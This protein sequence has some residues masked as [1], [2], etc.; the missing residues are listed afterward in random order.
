MSPA[1]LFRL[2]VAGA[3]VMTAPVAAHAQIGG[4]QPIR[5][6]V[7]LPAGATSDIVARLVADGIR[8]AVGQP[9]IVENRPGASG[10]IA[11]DAFKSAAPDGNTL[12]LAPIAV[13]VIIPLVFRNVNYDATKDFAPV[14]QVA[15]FEYAFAVAANHPARDLAKFVAWSKANPA[16]ASFG[17][18]GAGSLPHFL[19]VGFGRSA[20]IELVHVAYKGAAPVEADLMNGQITAGVSALS[21][22]VPLH[23]AGRLRILATSGAARSPLLPAVPTFREQGYPAGELVGWHGVFAP[24]GTPQPVVERL[25]SA[26]VAALRTSEV[27]EKFLMFGLEPTGTT[28][29]QL[30]AI[31]AADIARWAP[32]IKAT[33]FSAE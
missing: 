7:P 2:L 19:G 32:I 5:I 10:R 23:R 26:I 29:Q 21:D 28:P 30:A 15:K 22:F 18:P 4:K 3:I 1:R 27:R 31:V 9:I 16:P 33:G 25:S 12:L 14:A 11:V 6:L 20:G 24:A 17:S 13:P 8:D